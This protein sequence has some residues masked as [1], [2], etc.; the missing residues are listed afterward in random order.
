MKKTQ[1]PYVDPDV[2]EEVSRPLL[3]A[4]D[5][6]ST[7]IVAYLMDGLTGRRL[8]VRS[9]L[10]PQK[11]Y[12]ADVVTRSSYALEHGA[13]ILS[14]CAEEAV[15]HLLR[16]A[17]RECQRSSEDIVRIVMVGNTCMHHLFL[18]IPTD[19]LVV[20][21][22]KPVVK[23]A[24]KRTA[25][26]CGILVYPS[27]ELWWLPNIG[28]FVG[29]DTVAGILSSGMCGQEDLIL[30]V[31]VGTNAE[32]V[33]GSRHRRIACSTAAGPAFEGMKMSCGMRGNEGAIDHVF[34]ENGR[35]RYHV[36]GETE[37]LG[38]CGSGLLDAVACLLKTGAMDETGRMEKT[39]HFTPKVGVSQKDIRELQL[40][41]AAIA[42]GIRLLCSHYG[43][44]FSDIREVQLAGS[45]GTDM[46][47][48]SACAVGLFPGELKEKIRPVGN[49]AGEG[50]QMAALSVETY[51][52]CGRL[53]EETEF[54][55]LAGDRA[56]PDLF[57]E[58][59]LFPVQ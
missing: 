33:L 57:M 5:L 3:A 18:N 53:A 25:L 8:S 21:P 15:N 35:L 52:A 9:M 4:V 14:S 11:K 38:I 43:A 19:S 32:L 10:N 12:G 20:A 16:E 45:F 55:E 30:L 34:L 37:A 31:D 59:L 47:P 46:D 54:L 41:K 23:K 22:H 42:A 58:E 17:A 13:R 48:A 29:A 7:S 44:V 49:A 24:V 6:G 40:A 39:W 2:L 56:F 51:E 26:D 1:I 36:I 50:A 27:A 28:G